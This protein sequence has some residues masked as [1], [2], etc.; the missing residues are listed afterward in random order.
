MSIDP[1]LPPPPAPPP[2]TMRKFTNSILAGIMVIAVGVVA[3]QIINVIY[4]AVASH[5]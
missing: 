3:L 5:P 2:T 1:S 4:M